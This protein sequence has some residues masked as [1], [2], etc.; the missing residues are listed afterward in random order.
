[1]NLERIF[2]TPPDQPGGIA[3]TVRNQ[4]FPVEM[5]VA[6]SF[7]VFLRD[8]FDALDRGETSAFHD[9]MLQDAR[10]LEQ[11]RVALSVG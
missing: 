5:P 11:L 4:P 2:T 6:D 9:T 10:A 1:M 7:E 8:V 3:A